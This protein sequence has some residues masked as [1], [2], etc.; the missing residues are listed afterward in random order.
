MA[1]QILLSAELVTELLVA[2]W[3]P[4]TTLAPASAFDGRSRDA[5]AAYGV[6]AK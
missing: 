5:T 2:P 3:G 6:L 4:W 1:S